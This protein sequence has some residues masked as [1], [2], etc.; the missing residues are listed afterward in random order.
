MCGTE[1]TDQTPAETLPG[2]DAVQA[3]AS[4]LAA[5]VV[6]RYLTVCR[7][8]ADATQTKV[9]RRE[10]AAIGLGYIM[11][12]CEQSGPGLADAL[13]DQGKAAAVLMIEHREDEAKIRE[14]TKAS[15]A[16]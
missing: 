2:V 5:N 8:G 7:L 14:I 9:T 10:Q 12:V 3:P 15:L 1:Q 11:A 6:D 4:S 16:E 13:T